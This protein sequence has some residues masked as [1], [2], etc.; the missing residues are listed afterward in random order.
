MIYSI[1]IVLEAVENT[2]ESNPHR[3][4]PTAYLYDLRG[5]AAL[6]VYFFSLSLQTFPR[7]AQGYGSTHKD[8]LTWQLPFIR[9]FHMGR[10][11]VYIFFV[12][13]D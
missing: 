8:G 11:Y 13:S 7:L 2:S 4:S 9:T 6:F 1:R 5:F 10:G 3:R 12:V